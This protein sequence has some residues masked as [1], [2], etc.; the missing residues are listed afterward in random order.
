MI[1]DES[2][3]DQ[4]DNELSAF[5]V[6]PIMHLGENQC[7][8]MNFCDPFSGRLLRNFFFCASLLPAKSGEH[9]KSDSGLGRVPTSRRIG[10][11]STGAHH[12]VTEFFRTTIMPSMTRTGDIHMNKRGA[13]F[14]IQ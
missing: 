9:P 4:H 13:A 12:A 5:S 14:G 10:I 6:E 1:V 11:A 2:L 8:A 3:S 7:T